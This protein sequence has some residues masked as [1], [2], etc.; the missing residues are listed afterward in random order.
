MWIRLKSKLSSGNGQ[1]QTAAA[2]ERGHRRTPCGASR[3]IQVVE[4]G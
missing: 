1:A 2:C 3:T 4:P